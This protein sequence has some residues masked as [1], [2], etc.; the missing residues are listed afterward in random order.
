[1]LTRFKGII[2]AVIL[3][4][5]CPTFII[6][7]LQK[8]IPEGKSPSPETTQAPRDSEKEPP[9]ISVLMNDDSIRR[10]DINDYLT[11]V[12]LR[13][14]PASFELEALKAQAVVARTYALRRQASGGKHTGAA[15]CTSSDCCQGYYDLNDYLAD[16]GTNDNIDKIRNAVELTDN[17]VLV[18]NGELIDAT[19]YSCSGGM[20]ED[21]KAVWGVD[22]PYLLS[23][24][25]P[26]EENAA[27][28]VDT[29]TIDS[30]DFMKKLEVDTKKAPRIGKITY[31]SGG[32]VNT[33]NICG[34]EYKGTELRKK[35][36]LRSTAFAISIVG[37]TVTITTKGFGHRVGMSQYGADAMAVKGSGFP[38]ILAHYYRGTQLVTYNS[39]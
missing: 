19:Y 23:T 33:I 31:T 13:E 2:F 25:S 7:F 26:G 37:N 14:M 11:C 28:Y 30:A 29:V 15:V 5:V 8:E 6:G 20:T 27:H 10:I 16:G 21:A 12:V 38:D 9:K 18:Y 4:L 17:L 22:V 24:V 35:L 3:G 34:K 36:G 39:N 1:M 32:G